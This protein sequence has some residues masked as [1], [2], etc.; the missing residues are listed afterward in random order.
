MAT[1]D[2]RFLRRDEFETHEARTCI[3]AG[4]VLDDSRRPRLYSDQQ[5][6]RTPAEMQELFSDLPEALENTV[7]IAKRCN[8]VIELGKSYLPDYEIDSGETP[9]QYLA[10]IAREGLDEKAAA[11]LCALDDPEVYEQAAATR[12]GRYRGDGLSRLLPDCCRL[13]TLG[14]GERRA[15]GARPRLGCRFTG[16]LGSG[17][18][19]SRPTGV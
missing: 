11:G 12:T 15:G 9:E 4:Y 14:A 18:Y 2:V 1:N 10:R 6:L 3:Q 7:E 13:Y 8:V 5:Y 17:Y 19:G 16:G